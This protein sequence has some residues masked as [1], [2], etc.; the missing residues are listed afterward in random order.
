MA[1]PVKNYT[2][3][4]PIDLLNKLKRYSSEGHVSSVNAAVK[5]AIE[6]YVKNI[7]KQKLYE[8]MKAATQDPMFMA[9]LNEAID[10]FSYSDFEVTKEL[11]D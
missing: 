9:D 8:E 7:E 2:F 1:Q 11:E 5:E 3:S 6:S 4:L 10:D